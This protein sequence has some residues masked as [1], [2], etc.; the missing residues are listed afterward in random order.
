[1][2]VVFVLLKMWMNVPLTRT[3]VNIVAPITM[4]RTLAPVCQDTDSIAMD[5]SVMVSL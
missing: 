1:M 5:D 3:T 2:N 4:D